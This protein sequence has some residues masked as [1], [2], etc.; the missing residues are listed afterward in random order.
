M[1]NPF[2]K[3]GE[4]GLRDAYAQGFMRKCAERGVDPEALIKASQ[5][6]QSTR[7]RLGAYSAATLGPVTAGLAPALYAGGKSDNFGKGVLAPVAGIGGA[8]AGS[9]PG[10]MLRNFRGGGKV[11]SVVGGIMALLG[12]AAGAG[13]TTYALSQK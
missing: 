4:D 10:L 12:A 6:A 9:I 1:L 5:Q 3:T 11:R 2:A 8:A 7:S 13:E